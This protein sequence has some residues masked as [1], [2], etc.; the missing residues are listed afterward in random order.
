MHNI[1]DQRLAGQA[2]LLSLTSI[3]SLISWFPNRAP[4]LLLD[5]DRNSL[6]ISA[7][8]N[9]SMGIQAASAHLLGLINDCIRDFDQSA[10]LCSLVE[11][12]VYLWPQCQDIK[13]A[14]S[15]P[16]WHHTRGWTYAFSGVLMRASNLRN[17]FWW[18]HN[19]RCCPGEIAFSGFKIRLVL[20]LFRLGTWGSA[21]VLTIHP[22]RLFLCHS[23]Y[24]IF[25]S[26]VS[27]YYATGVPDNTTYQQ[28][29]QD[30]QMQFKQEG[31]PLAFVE[32]D[33][34]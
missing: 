3:A 31:L 27:S 13:C 5:A 7:V 22:V 12:R 6:V 1:R 28:V 15:L 23:R 32:L 25:C 11:R 2:Y 30:I 26:D 4:L 17:L 18:L 10:C 20:P 14:I 29:L 8:A 9:G 21:Q 16:F 33:Q 34:W 24:S 19:R